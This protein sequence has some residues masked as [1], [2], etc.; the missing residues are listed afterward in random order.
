MQCFVKWYRVAGRWP[1]RVRSGASG[2]GG[3]QTAGGGIDSLGARTDRRVPRKTI[4]GI[5]AVF[6]IC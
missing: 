5:R 2:S 3:R 1:T 4:F 6:I